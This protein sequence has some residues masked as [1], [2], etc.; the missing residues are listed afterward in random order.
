MNITQ[1]KFKIQYNNEQKLLIDI[2]QFKKEEIYLKGSSIIAN[3][4]NFADYDLYSDIKRNYGTEE[5]YDEFHKILKN[6]L[7]NENM[8]FL[9]FKIESKNSSKK[10]YYDNNW[11]YTEFNKYFVNV[12]YC[13][14]DI[15]IFFNNRFTE[16][17]C[18]YYFT[19]PLNEKS[20]IIEL[21][22]GI[23]ELKKKNNYFKIL[24]KIYLLAKINNDINKLQYLT[25]IFNSDLG[26]LYKNINN[27]DAIKN[28]QKYY[29][30][31]LT[32]K[33]IETNL[34]D[35]NYPLNYKNEYNKQKK[36][37]NIEAKKIYNEIV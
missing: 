17:S 2:F 35:I 7:D 33:R 11:T 27:I 9:E 18:N 8:Y 15:V 13:K 28:I 25:N 12:L 30:D 4:H 22:R 26:I 37:L 6:I 29:N 1:E 31:V 16:S 19:K 10:W 20:V 14:I 23:I 36:I 21:N 5:I 24:K 34:F 32:K 3:I